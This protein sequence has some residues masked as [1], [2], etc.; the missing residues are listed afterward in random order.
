MR[1]AA[2]AEGCGSMAFT[3]LRNL[4]QPRVTS[5]SSLES[6]S[7]VAQAGSQITKKPRITCFSMLSVGMTGVCH[8]D[9]S[10]GF[11]H[12]RLTFVN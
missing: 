11:P 2:M 4:V 3:C 9:E 7:H 6:E 8:H 12:T 5:F 10:Q 1:R